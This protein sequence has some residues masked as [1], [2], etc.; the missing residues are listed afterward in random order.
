MTVHDWA[1]KYQR[2]QDGMTASTL[3]RSWL[4]GCI[5]V[6]RSTTKDDRNGIDYWAELRGGA[7]IGIDHKIREPGCRRYWKKGCPDLPME[8]WSVFPE[9][10]R[11]GVIGWTLSEEKNTDYVLFTFD[12]S[13]TDQAFLLP[14]QLLRIAFLNHYSEW[15]S[16]YLQ[17]PQKSIRGNSRWRSQAAFVP[18]PVVLLAVNEQLINRL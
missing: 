9:G 12:K 7:R 11:S 2:S 8:L 14:F 10:G 16:Q 3:L 5:N 13:D 1:T 18:S 15:C 6:R 4:P 17:P